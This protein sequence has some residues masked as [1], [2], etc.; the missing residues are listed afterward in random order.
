MSGVRAPLPRGRAQTVQDLGMIA[1]VVLWIVMGGAL[2][3]QVRGLRQLSETTTQVGAALQ[4]TGQTMESLSGVPLAGDQVAEAGRQI[5]AAGASTIASGR[6]SRDS[7][8]NLR[9]MLWVFLAVIPTVPVLVLYLPSR[10]IA[11]RE[12][13]ALQ[14]MVDEHGED[15]VLH[16][17]LAQRGL[18]TAPYRQLLQHGADPFADPGGPR[19]RELAEAE[20]AR[21]GVR[22]KPAAG[23]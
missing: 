8:H 1:W 6:S 15:P 10:V 4:Q 19:M 23:P 21:M 7:I 18:L 16:R 12:R 22:A 9:W 11:A 13:R 2:A 14:R 3:G 20:L 17:M 5:E